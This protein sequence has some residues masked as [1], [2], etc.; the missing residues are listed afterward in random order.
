MPQYSYKRALELQ[1]PRRCP[2]RAG[3]SQAGRGGWTSQASL[4]NLQY[5]VHQPNQVPGKSQSGITLVTGELTM[6]TGVT[7]HGEGLPSGAI[8]VVAVMKLTGL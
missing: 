2:G 8:A 5:M 1:P 7:L 3:P 6:Y 4:H